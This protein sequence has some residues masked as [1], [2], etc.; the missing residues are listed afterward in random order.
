LPI[1]RRNRRFKIGKEKQELRRFDI[2][3]EKQEV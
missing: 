1:A 3:K 2:G